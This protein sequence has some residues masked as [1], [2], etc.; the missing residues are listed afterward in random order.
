[1]FVKAMEFG[2][3]GEETTVESPGWDAVERALRSLDGLKNDSV[4]LDSVGRSYLGVAG[5]AGD[6]YVLAGFLDGFGSFICASGRED[7]AVVDVPVAGDT[8]AYESKHVVD[9]NVVIDAA[10]AFYERGAL[11]ERLRWEKQGR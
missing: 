2:P 8:N 7:G 3:G 1:M 4:T 11:L 5:G 6:R 10:R 9:I